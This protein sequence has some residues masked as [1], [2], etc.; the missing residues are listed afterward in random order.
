MEY[1]LSYLNPQYISSYTHASTYTPRLY[2]LHLNV[3]T[4]AYTHTS[5]Q[6][7]G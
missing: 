4:D 5:A 7:G 6:R 2:V 1:I 3:D